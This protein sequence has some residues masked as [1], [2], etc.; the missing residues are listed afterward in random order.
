MSLALILVSISCV[1]C[2][3][4]KL[5]VHPLEKDFRSVKAGET[6]TAPK[7]SF[8]VTSYWLSEVAGIE[9]EK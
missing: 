8:L 2:A 7:D 6:I 1:G 9:V 3:G 4:N 5:V